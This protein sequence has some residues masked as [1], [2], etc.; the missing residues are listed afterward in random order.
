MEE[1][2]FVSTADLLNNQLFMIDNRINLAPVGL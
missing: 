2:E 1:E